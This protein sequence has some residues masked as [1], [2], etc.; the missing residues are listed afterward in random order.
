MLASFCNARRYYVGYYERKGIKGL[1][2]SESC[3]LQYQLSK[4][5]MAP[6]TSGLGVD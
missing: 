2:S 6:Y 1:P 5:N 3:D 4:Q